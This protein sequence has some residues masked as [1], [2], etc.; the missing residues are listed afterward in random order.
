MMDRLVEQMKELKMRDQMVWGRKNNI[1]VCAELV[2]I[3]IV[4]LK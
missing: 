3:S 1:W 4:Y 2:L